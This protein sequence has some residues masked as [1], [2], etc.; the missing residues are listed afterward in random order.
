[1]IAEKRIREIEDQI[2]GLEYAITMIAEN[3]DLY[4]RDNHITVIFGAEVVEVSMRSNEISFDDLQKKTVEMLKE[5]REKPS[6]KD[7]TNHY[8]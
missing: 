3:K 4:P 6:S 7:S 2:S 1:M 8:G 5:I